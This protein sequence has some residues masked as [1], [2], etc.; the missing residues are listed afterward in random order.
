MLLSL[1]AAPGVAEAQETVSAEA[2]ARQATESVVVISSADRAGR[3]DGVGAGFVVSRDG[4]IATSLHVIGEGRPISVRFP[5]G[6]RLEASHI[7]AWDRKLDLAILRVP[8]S[9]LK[10]LSLGNSDLLRQ[11][12]P[13]VAIGSPMGLDNS[14][15]QGVVSARRDFEGIEMIQ[16]AIPIEPGNSGGP[17]L[18]GNGRVQGILTMKHTLTANLG[19]AMPVNALHSLLDR[20]NTVPMTRWVAFNGL[21]PKE[22]TSVMGGRWKRKGGRIVVDGAGQGFGGRALCLFAQEPSSRP[23]EVAAAVRL[24]DEGGAAGL[25]FASDGQ[26]RHYGFYPSAGQLRLTRFDGPSVYSWTILQQTNS[27]HYR[28]G[29]WN[30]LRVRVEEEKM[31][32]FVNDELVFESSD[33]GLKEGKA[34]LAKFRDTAASFRDFHLGSGQGP[35][36]PVSRKEVEDI[37]AKL[38]ARGGRGGE[39]PE[40]ASKPEASQAALRERARELER[41]AAELRR[42]AALLHE[43]TAREAL[44]KEL[45]RP[46]AEI[47]LW[48]AA[49]LVAR[50]DNPELEIEPYE[51]QLRGMAREL[52]D[53]IPDEADGEERLKKLTA[54]MF[55]ENGFHGSRNDYYNRENSYVSSVLDDR[56]GL[57]ITL[58]VVFLELA[59]RIGLEAEGIPLPGHFVIQAKTGEGGARLIDVFEGGKRLSRTEAMEIALD[60]TGEP[61]RPEHLKPAGKGE[62]IARMIRNL[63]GAA[64]RSGSGPDSLKYLDALLAIAPAAA[65]ERLER[66]ML[67]ARAGQRDEAKEDV[68]WLLEHSPEGFDLE[69]LRELLRSLEQ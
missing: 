26:D 31:L 16:L 28:P 53:R 3:P 30:W 25:A 34:G 66:A 12:A 41:Q 58:S 69:R 46:E 44:V 24:E 55:E 9:G 62:I 13:V 36:S 15:V 11:G 8:A 64:N 68:R 38:A 67:R 6:K 27:P 63:L 1:L 37:Q 61:L 40:F 48:R 42:T 17:L 43:R 51:R 19:F 65:P 50:L 7:H 54:Y 20:P 45:A 22:W 10:P 29:E 52:K 47:D 23:Y 49:L 18:D 39:M 33:D 57:P 2:L 32:C 56:E 35:S 5:D 60:F 59:R 21:D 4:L 14:V